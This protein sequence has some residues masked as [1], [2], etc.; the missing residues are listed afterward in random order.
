MKTITELKTQAKN[1]KRVSVYLDGKYYC[2]LDLATVVKNRL[3]VGVQIDEQTLINIQMESELQACFDS[4]L[5]LISV[6]L[7]TEKEVES[8]LVKKGY[9]PEIVSRA[10]EKV[11]LYGFLNDEE[12]AKKYAQSYSKTKGKRLIGLQLKQKGVST[13]DVETAISEIENQ[14]ESAKILAEKYLKN[15]EIDKKILQKCYKY[16]LSK[17]FDYDDAKYAISSFDIED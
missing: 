11:K 16:L 6:S 2:G 14:G 1:K 10:I 13:E 9:L 17:G 3:K 7:K 8:R 15:K 12:Y 5:N 4:A